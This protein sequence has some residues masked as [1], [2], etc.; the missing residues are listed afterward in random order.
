M[1]Y[2]R[3]SLWH[4]SVFSVIVR[5]LSYCFKH[6][7]KDVQHEDHRCHQAWH[8]KNCCWT[9]SALA[10]KPRAEGGSGGRIWCQFSWHTAW[11]C[12][13]CLETAFTYVREE[14]PHRSTHPLYQSR[15]QI[16][17]EMNMDL[18]LMNVKKKCTFFSMWIAATIVFFFV[19]FGR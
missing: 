1:V 10:K 5:L 6:R 7:W 4:F 18:L 17:L 8:E 16:V 3:L 13:G 2:S 15:I 14:K 12:Q 9:G 11:K 19:L